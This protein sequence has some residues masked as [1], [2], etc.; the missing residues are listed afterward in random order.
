MGCILSYVLELLTEAILQCSMYPLLKFQFTLHLLEHGT[1]VP[2][3]LLSAT[4][5]S[6]ALVIKCAI[7]SVQREY[8]CIFGNPSS[9]VMYSLQFYF[10]SE[11][12]IKFLLTMKNELTSREWC[13]D[14]NQSLINTELL[15]C[16]LPL[17]CYSFQPASL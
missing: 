14:H 16:F 13:C 15:I 6:F 11:Q 3:T 10:H 8:F 9:V 5:S 2:Y 4:Y 7:I 12:I 1:N 17:N